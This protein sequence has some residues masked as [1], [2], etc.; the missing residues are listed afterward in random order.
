MKNKAIEKL[1]AIQTRLESVLKS[2]NDEIKKYEDMRDQAKYKAEKADAEMDAAFKK[3]DHVAYKKLMSEKHDNEEMSLMIDSKI[4][5]IKKAPCITELEYK[6]I[7]D[8]ITTEIDAFMA[9]QEKEYAA[10]LEQLLIRRNEIGD[11]IRKGNELYALA[12]KRLLKN[13][14][15][16]FTPS[17]AFIRH[18]WE[19]KK[20]KNDVLLSTIKEMICHPYSYEILAKNHDRNEII[21]W[22]ERP[23]WAPKQ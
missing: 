6:Q 9:E 21:Y 17:G 22:N 14:C 12:Q 7:V 20:Y 19:E 2:H 10:L 16:A 4:S 11:T 3:M 5:E 13:P 8:E 23:S 18:E 15:G 1:N